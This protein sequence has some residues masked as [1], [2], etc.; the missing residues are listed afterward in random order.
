VKVG[1]LTAGRRVIESGLS[2]SDRV[3]VTGLQRVRPG[4]TVVS[5]PAEESLGMNAEKPAPATAESRT[6]GAAK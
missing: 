1:L 6:A 5:K 4:Q 2:A 3:V